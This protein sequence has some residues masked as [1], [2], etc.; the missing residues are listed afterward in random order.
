MIDIKSLGNR[1][2][3]LRKQQGITQ[4]ELA[5]LLNV[6]FQA[7]SNW[8]R[9]IA[10]PDIDNLCRI[11]S[12]FNILVDDLLRRGD[13][14]MILGIDGGGTKTE[15]VVASMSGQV[16][17]RIESPGTNPNDIGF[18]K[19]YS[20]ISSGI[21]DALLSFPSIAFVFG[22]IAGMNSGNYRQQMSTMLKKKYPSLRI[23]LQ[24]DAANLFAID[25]SADM[26]LISGTGSVAFVRQK[27]T[28]VRI[29]G[30]GYLFDSAGSAYDIGRDAVSAALAD[31]DSL[32]APS[33]LTRLL[34]DRL[35]T[36]T[37]WSA[38]GELYNGGKPYIASLASAVFEA[39]QRGDTCACEIID[40]SAKRLAELLELGVS[41]Y[42]AHPRAIANGGIFEHYTDIILSHIKKY[43]SV[44]LVVCDL[45]PIYGACRLAHRLSGGIAGREFYQ[46]FKESYGGMK[47]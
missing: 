41:K 36:E 47:K 19:A 40:R 28:Y 11:A 34:L 21:N 7:V 38:I 39:Y 33:L 25:D 2:K 27:D 29:G 30:W 20:I 37:V 17:W 6:S 43:T 45:P 31:E 46:S 22:G 35:N 9:G 5:G 23:E 16:L 42:G 18:D 8:E 14:K 10:P 15:F 32:R 13:E 3:E 26:T 4:N 1:I 24:N 44:D 12:H